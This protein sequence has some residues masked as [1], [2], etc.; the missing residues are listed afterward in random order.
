MIAKIK[1]NKKITYLAIFLVAVGFLVLSDMI[2]KRHGDWAPL[3]TKDFMGGVSYYD[4]NFTKEKNGE[5]VH[6]RIKTVYQGQGRDF[7]VHLM[8]NFLLENSEKNLEGFSY[9]INTDEINCSAKT[10]R[11]DSTVLYDEKHNV[12]HS[13]K[14]QEEP[15]KD[16]PMNSDLEELLPRI[17]R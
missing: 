7:F 10:Y 8:G 11:I 12:L 6:V 14:N 4:R 5:V 9:V 15:W 2:R 17:C 13:R 3:K 16:I 1:A